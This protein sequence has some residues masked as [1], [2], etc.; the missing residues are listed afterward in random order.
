MTKIIGNLLHFLGL[1]LFIVSVYGYLVADVDA[2]TLIELIGGKENLN[3]VYG[4]FL[5]AAFLNATYWKFFR[6]KNA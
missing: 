6:S 2:N 4:A 3:F 1:L 5:V